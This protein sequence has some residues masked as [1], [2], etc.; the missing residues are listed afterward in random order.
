MVEKGTTYSIEDPG[1]EDMMFDGWYLDREYKRRFYMNQPITDDI[2]IYA[3]LVPLSQM[4]TV[5]LYYEDDTTPVST[6][7]TC[8]A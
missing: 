8:H 1:M 4:H 7:S 6:F 3:K 5:S 2:A